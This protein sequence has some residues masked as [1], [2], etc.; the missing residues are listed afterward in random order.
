MRADRYILGHVRQ[1]ARLVI[2]PVLRSRRSVLNTLR[3][4][5]LNTPPATRCG[6]A[7][8]IRSARVSVRR[9]PG[10]P[11]PRQNGSHGPASASDCPGCRRGGPARSAGPEKGLAYLHAGQAW[12]PAP[13]RTTGCGSAAAMAAFLFDPLCVSRSCVRER[14]AGAGPA[15][16]CGLWSL[17]QPPGFFR[18]AGSKFPCRGRLPASPERTQGPRPGQAHHAASV[19]PPLVLVVHLRRGDP[20]IFRHPPMLP[21]LADRQRAGGPAKLTRQRPWRWTQLARKRRARPTH[22]H[23]H[24]FPH[25]TLLVTPRRE[26]RGAAATRAAF[27]RMIPPVAVPEGMTRAVALH[28]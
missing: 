13:A 17:L 7:R 27:A 6:G 19:G 15:R 18:L 3:A 8:L 23:R 5:V 12:G 20:K 22:R 4:A 11:R 10:A 25:K 14:C 28:P 2:S 16:R 26:K 9:R 21:D 1:L 24:I